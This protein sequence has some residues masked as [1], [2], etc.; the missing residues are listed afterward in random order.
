MKKKLLALILLLISINSAQ[1]AIV[2]RVDNILNLGSLDQDGNLIQQLRILISLHDHNNKP[3][4]DGTYKLKACLPKPGRRFANQFVFGPSRTRCAQ[5]SFSIK[6]N[7][8]NVDLPLD[9]FFVIKGNKTRTFEG[10]PI[11]VRISKNSKLE[12]KTR[13]RITEESIGKILKPIR[14]K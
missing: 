2:P 12:S 14:P 11:T 7:Q 3:P 13:F 1:A 8:S 10:T 6:F 4:E 5:K 9:L